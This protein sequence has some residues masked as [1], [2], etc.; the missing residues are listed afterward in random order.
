MLVDLNTRFADCLPS[1][2]ALVD[3]NCCSAAAAAAITFSPPDDRAVLCKYLA[4]SE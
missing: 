1:T 4:R 3:L 2:D